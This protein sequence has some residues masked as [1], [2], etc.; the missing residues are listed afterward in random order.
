MTEQQHAEKWLAEHGRFRR[1]IYADELRKVLG[2]QKGQCTWCG[3]EVKSPRRSW[4]SQNCTDAFMERSPG[5]ASRRV[6]KRDKGV[7]AICGRDTD[8]MMN[9]FR[10]I[11]RQSKDD[12]WGPPKIEVLDALKELVSHWQSLGFNCRVGRA[13]TEVSHLWEADHI[14]PVV[15]GGGCCRIDNL[16]TACMACHKA[17]SKKLAARLALS[18]KQPTDTVQTGLF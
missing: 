3:G 2:R 12:R 18:R 10:M 17:E 5:P 1:S 11:R 8:R 16:R 14:I 4:C 9:L 13:W 15:E 6:Y 7:C